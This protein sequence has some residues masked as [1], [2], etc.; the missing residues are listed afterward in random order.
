MKSNAPDDFLSKWQDIFD[1]VFDN[2]LTLDFFNLHR[3]CFVGYN[4]EN[5][6]FSFFQT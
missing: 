6:E 2:A 5:T 1:P 4:D 3:R